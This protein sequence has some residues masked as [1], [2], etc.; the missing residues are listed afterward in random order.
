MSS[1]CLFALLCF[2]CLLLIINLELM[3]ADGNLEIYRVQSDGLLRRLYRL[4]VYNSTE[5]P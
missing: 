3:M 5:Y 4:T 2:A 1:A